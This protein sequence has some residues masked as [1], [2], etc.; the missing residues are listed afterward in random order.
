MCRVCD[1]RWSWWWRRWW[2]WWCDKESVIFGGPNVTKNPTANCN[3]SGKQSHTNNNRI[4]PNEIAA[5]A[6]QNQQIG[7]HTRHVRCVPIECMRATNALFVRVYG[8][9]CLH[10]WLENNIPYLF[11]PLSVG[12]SWL[13]LHFENKEK[14][15]NVWAAGI[16]LGLMRFSSC[17]NWR[18]IYG[19]ERT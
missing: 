15:A 17:S 9:M 18:K 19:H 5:T 6:K 4:K 11:W 1:W 13:R 8:T 2:W 3:S 7:T 12:N 16:D 14:I 10:V